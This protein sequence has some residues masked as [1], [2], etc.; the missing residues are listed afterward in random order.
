MTRKNPLFAAV[1]NFLL[2]GA[3]TIYIGRRT[4]FGLAMTIGGTMA[5]AIEIS[6]SPAFANSIPSLWPFLLG[7][8][9]MMKLALAADAWREAKS[10]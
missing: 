8:L 9:V 2:F 4:G 1:L 5:Q 7:G 3:G 6:V 10:T